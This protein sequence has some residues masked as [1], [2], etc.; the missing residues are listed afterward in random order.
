MVVH[1][2]HQ[3]TG[4]VE[5]EES[6]RLRSG[7][8]AEQPLALLPTPFHPARPRPGGSDE[9]RRCAE[10]SFKPLPRPRSGSQDAIAPPPLARQ[11]PGC[12]SFLSLR[13]QELRC[14]LQSLGTLDVARRSKVGAPHIEVPWADLLRRSLAR[15][16]RRFFPG[17]L[18]RLAEAYCACA[19][20]LAGRHTW[21]GRGSSR[22]RA[23]VPAGCGEWGVVSHWQGAPSL[24]WRHSRGFSAPAQ[25]GAG[26]ED[27]FGDG[28]VAGGQLLVQLCGVRGVW[29]FASR[30]LPHLQDHSDR[31]F[32]RG[33]DVPDL[34]L[35]RRPFPRPH[36]GH[37][38]GRLPRASR[39][40]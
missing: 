28:V 40:Y 15:E 31:R 5:A 29:V 4:E 38:W 9:H 1:T 26:Q 21:V 7:S 24:A 27:G 33:Q 2:F 34:P 35:L 6:L 8:R 14:F 19:G 25:L 13:P 30:P 32:E 18:H 39:G 11:P 36:R 23:A 10:S 17:T 20:A 22:R 16:R 37:N 12:T 3:G